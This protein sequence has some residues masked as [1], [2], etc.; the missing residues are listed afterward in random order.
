MTRFDDK[1][2]Y[3]NYPSFADDICGSDSE[4]HQ[5]KMSLK[6]FLLEFFAHDAVGEIKIFYRKILRLPRPTF[7]LSQINSDIG[8]SE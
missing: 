2:S 3:K 4:Y 5:Q 6:L 8:L 1:N 7:L